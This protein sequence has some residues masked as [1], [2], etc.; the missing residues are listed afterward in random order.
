MEDSWRH[1][2]LSECEGGERID[3]RD[4]IPDYWEGVGLQVVLHCTLYLFAKG[5]RFP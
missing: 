2:T 1:F 5:S 4:S 3:D